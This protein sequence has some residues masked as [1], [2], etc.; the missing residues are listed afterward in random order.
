M[1]CQIL[2]QRDNQ[3]RNHLF[4]HFLCNFQG[5]VPV[6][7]TVHH[8]QHQQ[9]FLILHS[10]S[11]PVPVLPASFALTSTFVQNHA[12]RIMRQDLYCTTNDTTRPS[13]TQRHAKAHTSTQ[14]HTKAHKST[15]KHTHKIQK[16]D[17]K[18]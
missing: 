10:S 4:A 12:S 16:T 9:P 13:N 8:V 15:Q 3:F 7:C 1:Y 5:I 17:H 6:L 14:K 2:F 18:K 11:S